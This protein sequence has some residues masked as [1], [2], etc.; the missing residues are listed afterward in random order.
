M[1]SATTLYRSLGSSASRVA[2]VWFRACSAAQR[3]YSTSTARLSSDAAANPQEP[4]K[5]IPYSA[6]T[7][8]VPKEHFPLEKRVAAS[9]E[10]VARMVKPGLSVAIESGA[11]VASNFSDA[12]Y[13][14]AGATIV[15]N[16]W[17]DSDIVIKVCLFVMFGFVCFVL[18]WLLFQ[19]LDCKCVPRIGTLKNGPDFV[20]LTNSL[21]LIAC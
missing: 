18:C 4:P 2:S 11:G 17:K 7:V 8:G 16:V 9:P 12:D 14:A 21:S 13:Q 20:R 10:S 6:L 19:W 15:D 1:S 5:G 3:S